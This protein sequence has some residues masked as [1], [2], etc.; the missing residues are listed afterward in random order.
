L[1]IKKNGNGLEGAHNLTPRGAAHAR[2]DHRTVKES[3]VGEGRKKKI[4]DRL[5]KLGV[6]IVLENKIE[7]MPPKTEPGERQVL[8]DEK[9]LMHRWEGLKPTTGGDDTNP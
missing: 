9:K 6:R 2:I 1:E 8:D 4:W 3:E 5:Y 7:G